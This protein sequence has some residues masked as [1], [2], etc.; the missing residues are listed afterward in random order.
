[1]SGDQ[2]PDSGLNHE[3]LQKQDTL[4]AMSSALEVTWKYRA[5]ILRTTLIVAV[6]VG[7]IS[8]ILPKSFTA[9]ASILPDM[10]FLSSLQDKLGGGIQDLVNAAGLN[11]SISPSEMYPDMMLSETVLRRVIFHK[12]TTEAYPA[13]VNLI[14]YFKWD[15]PDSNVNF[16]H[17]INLFRKSL[18]TTTIDKKTLIITLEVEAPEQQL[19][20]DIAN[21]MVAE[22]DY[23]QR[24]FRQTNASEQRKF[25]EQ[26][27]AEVK[28]DLANA[29]DRLKVF[30]EKNRSAIQSPD[31][32][33]QQNRLQRDVDMNSTIF[34]Q[35]KGQY[36]LAKLDEIKNTPIVSILDSARPPAKRSSPKRTMMVLVAFFLT[37]VISTI[38][39]NVLER[40]KEEGARRE[41]VGKLFSVL[42]TIR[43]DTVSMF[44]SRKREHSN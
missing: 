2:N 22:L 34:I 36:E 28:I 44:R 21:E 31:L 15:D 16:E 41:D 11:G 42:R 9:T 24:N 27:L 23:F 19:C 5:R 30:Q 3:S 8:M 38:W 12:Y 39:Y 20:A 35:L 13:P 6:V 43:H 4:S 17:C 10:D 33:L 26:R 25:L 40:S 29:E 37:F 1:M 7:A 18:V 14:Q 32:Q